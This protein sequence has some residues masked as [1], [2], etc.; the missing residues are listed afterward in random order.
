MPFE[1]ASNANSSY[2]SSSNFLSDNSVAGSVGVSSAGFD[3]LGASFKA[4]DTNRDG[5]LDRGEFEQFIQGGY[6]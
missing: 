2:T 5:R 4:A 3:L 6:K 1:A